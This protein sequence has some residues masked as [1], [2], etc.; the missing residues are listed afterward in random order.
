VRH[1]ATAKIAFPKPGQ[2]GRPGT[3]LSRMTTTWVLVGISLAV[4][5][6]IIV[7]LVLVI[8]RNRRAAAR[9]TPSGG[10]AEAIRD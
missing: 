2:A 5:L 9:V 7:G 1:T 6:V 8:R 4:G 3:L 10:E